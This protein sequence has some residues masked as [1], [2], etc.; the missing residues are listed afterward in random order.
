MF[1]RGFLCI[2]SLLPGDEK[3]FH[4]AVDLLRMDQMLVSALRRFGDFILFMFIF[5]L[6]RMHVLGHAIDA[7]LVA[8]EYILQHTQ[9]LFLFA[10]RVLFRFDHCLLL[11]HLQ[12]ELIHLVVLNDIIH[13][14]DQLS[15]ILIAL[16]LAL[17]HF[18]KLILQC[19]P[20]AVLFP[21]HTV[22]DT[23][24]ADRFAIV[25]PLN[26]LLGELAVHRI[27]WVQQ[28]VVMQIDI[29]FGGERMP[30]NLQYRFS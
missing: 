16:R 20:L 4:L 19:L 10:Q 7:R 2:D 11:T 28:L 9:R 26:L 6:H 25:E 21:K 15:G 12:L 14:V 30:W 8:I 17:L 3:L 5:T 22:N 23:L 1:Q 27:Q 29:A 18:V 13:L 24:L